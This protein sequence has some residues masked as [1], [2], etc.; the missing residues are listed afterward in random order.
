MSILEYA[1]VEDDRQEDE[2]CYSCEMWEELPMQAGWGKCSGQDMLRAAGLQGAFI[3]H[4][5]STAWCQC[6]DGPFM[7]IDEGDLDTIADRIFEEE[8]EDGSQD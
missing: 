8:R 5:E 1:I 4:R 3:M 2:S 7:G 6:Y